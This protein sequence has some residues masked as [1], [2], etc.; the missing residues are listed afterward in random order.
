MKVIYSLTNFGKTFVPILEAIT[1]GGNWLA[2][3][4]GEFVQNNMKVKEAF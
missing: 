3:Q 2:T 1:A 4:K